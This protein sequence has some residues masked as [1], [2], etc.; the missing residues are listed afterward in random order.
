VTIAS[1]PLDEYETKVLRAIDFDYEYLV[2]VIPGRA[3]VND[4]AAGAALAELKKRK[5]VA[6]EGRGKFKSVYLTDAGKAAQ[7]ALADA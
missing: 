1:K 2:L 7:E 6:F 4:F 3:G 5:L